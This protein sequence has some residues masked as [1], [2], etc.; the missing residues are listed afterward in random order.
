M[1]S[2]IYEDGPWRVLDS[3]LKNKIWANVQGMIYSASRFQSIILGSIASGC[4][5]KQNLMAQ[6]IHDRGYFRVCRK[7]RENGREGHAPSNL[8][9]LARLCPL[10]FPTSLSISTIWGPTVPQQGYGRHF[11]HILCLVL[12]KVLQ[13]FNRIYWLQDICSLNGDRRHPNNQCDNSNQR[14]RVIWQSFP[15]SSRFL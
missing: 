3:K 10:K 6:R 15:V 9:P 4:I 13:E 7:G 2:W 14:N 11:K 1:C 12:G 5:V 8:L